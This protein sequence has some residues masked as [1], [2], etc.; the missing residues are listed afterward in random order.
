VGALSRGWP[1]QPDHSEPMSPEN[2][3]NTPDHS[4]R[5]AYAVC[6]IFLVG[7]SLVTL[8]VVSDGIR[9]GEL[10]KVVPKALPSATATPGGGNQ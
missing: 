2:A 1:G 6:A 4:Y 8:A 9:L 7:C 3:E 5:F 10:E